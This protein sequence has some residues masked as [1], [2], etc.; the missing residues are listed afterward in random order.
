MYAIYFTLGF[1]TGC[2]VILALFF[3]WYT[4]EETKEP[5]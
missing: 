5:K 3:R 1:C 2:I 4:T